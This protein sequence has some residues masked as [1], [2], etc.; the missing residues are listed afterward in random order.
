MF[1]LI[2]EFYLFCSYCNINNI[3]PRLWSF[4]FAERLIPKICVSRKMTTEWRAGA[5]LGSSHK[6]CKFLLL[7]CKFLRMVH[8]WFHF[9]RQRRWSPLR[10]A[11]LHYRQFTKEE[12]QGTKS[13]HSFLKQQPGLSSLILLSAKDQISA[14]CWAFHFSA[15]LQPGWAYRHICNWIRHFW[16]VTNYAL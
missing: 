1:T 2:I 12:I 13:V 14:L 11:A 10:V 6:F 3:L 16:N 15:W 8:S 4:H 7:S 5:L 9:S